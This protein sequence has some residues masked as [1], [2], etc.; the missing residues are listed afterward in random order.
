MSVSR[1]QQSDP[2]AKNIMKWS[3]QVCHH[4]SLLYHWLYSL[5]DIQY[6]CDLSYSWKLTSLS[7]IHRFSPS[8]PSQLSA[9]CVQSV[10]ALSRFSVVCI[11]RVRSHGTDLP[12]TY[13]IQHHTPYSPM[14]SQMARFHSFFYGWVISSVYLFT[15]LLMDIQ[16]ASTP[17]LLWIMLQ[18]RFSSVQLLS[19][20]RLIA[21]PWTAAR[22]ASLS[23]TNSK[24]LLKLMSIESVMPANHLILCYLLL[25]PPSIFPS[26]RV[27]YNESV[28]H[29]RWPK[30]WSFSFS[31]SIFNEYSGLI[32]F[33]II[34]WIS[35]QS[36]GLSRVLQPHSSKASMQWRY[37]CIYLFEP[38]YIP[39]SSVQVFPFLHIFANTCYLS[40]WW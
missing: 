21:T 20:V 39:T 31:I 22:Q 37:G 14:L 4:T 18:W 35:L 32:S 36:K 5:C 7:C 10:S 25:L 9:P 27:F 11:P 2:T 8:T 34:G 23:I 38:I 1:V 26:I 24:S 3:P 6:P 40:F 28:L 16:I 15:H 17:W 13:F 30:Y 29:I 12:L 33:R 19:R